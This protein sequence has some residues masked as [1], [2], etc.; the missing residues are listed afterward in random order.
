MEI[1]RWIR[2]GEKKHRIMYEEERHRQS[3]K[4]YEKTMS[5]PDTRFIRKGSVIANRAAHYIY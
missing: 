5:L 4:I 1:V 3:V 2:Q